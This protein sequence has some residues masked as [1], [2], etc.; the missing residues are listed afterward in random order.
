MT[1]SLETSS[2]VYSS[3]TMSLSMLVYRISQGEGLC[4]S[5]LAWY[6]VGG[7][8]GTYYNG[9][10]VYQISV[11]ID[12][13]NWSLLGCTRRIFLA[14]HKSWEDEQSKYERE[15]EILSWMRC[16]DRVVAEHA[17]PG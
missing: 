3:M 5:S 4:I 2:S 15:G 1:C 7:H 8:Q 9:R 11:T 10:V 13:L 17:G 6:S 14:L 16:V 12:Y